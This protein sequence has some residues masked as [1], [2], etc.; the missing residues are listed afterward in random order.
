[1]PR[2]KGKSG[3]RGGRGNRDVFHGGPL[4]VKPKPKPKKNT[5][6]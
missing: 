3:S 1:M 4:P 5:A 6:S 2:G